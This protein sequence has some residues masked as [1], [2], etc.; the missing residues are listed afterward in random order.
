MLIKCNSILIVVNQ[1]VTSLETCV[2]L[3]ENYVPTCKW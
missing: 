2:F 3:R 1:T